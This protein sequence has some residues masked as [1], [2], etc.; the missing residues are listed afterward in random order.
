[1]KKSEKTALFLSMIFFLAGFSSCVMQQNYSNSLVPVFDLSGYDFEESK[2]GFCYESLESEAVEKLGKGNCTWAYNWTVYPNNRTKD[3]SSGSTVWGK[4]EVINFGKDKAV[5]FSPMTWGREAAADDGIDELKKVLD[6]QGE[7][8]KFLLGFNEPNMYYDGGGCFMI[9][10]EAASLWP[11]V[12]K[13][14]EDYG[15]T[16]VGPAMADTRNFDYSSYDSSISSTEVY[17]DAV[18]WFDAFIDCYKSANSG[19]SPKFDYF[20]FHCYQNYPNGFVTIIDKYYEKYGKPVMMTEFCANETYSSNNIKTL[21]E[22]FQIRTMTQKIQYLDHSPKAGPYAW[23]IADQNSYAVYNPL[24]KGKKL[25]K[26][27]KIYTYM[28]AF[29]TE[30]WYEAGKGIPAVQYIDSSVC[31][32]DSNKETVSS[33]PWASYFEFEENSDSASS[34]DLPVAIKSF[35]DGCYADY[36]IKVEEGSSYDLTL[37]YSSTA[38]QRIEVLCDGKGVGSANLASTDGLW[39]NRVISLDLSEG[40]HT[41]RLSSSGSAGD[42][43]LAWL[44]FDKSGTYSLTEE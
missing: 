8:V 13:V 40:K 28:S 12:E 32:F 9:P 20:A 11:K 1:M 38:R 35:G 6:E 26:L 42:V 16:L 31:V 4:S 44:E 30:K 27:G 39:V 14:A 29:N 36:Q 24:V 3:T 33:S 23:F 43:K 5:L 37:R 25:T 7:G 22:D 21:G 41:L 15:L 2:R 19:S 10:S 18:A 17:E 34:S